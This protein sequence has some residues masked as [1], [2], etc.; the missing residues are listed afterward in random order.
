M[1]NHEFD[2][3]EIFKKYHEKINDAFGIDIEWDEN[4][5]TESC[6]AYNKICVVK[7]IEEVCR[8]TNSKDFMLDSRLREIGIKFLKVKYHFMKPEAYVIYDPNNI[9]TQ[10]SESASED[11]DYLMLLI[12]KKSILRAIAD[13]YTVPEYLINLQNMSDQN[14]IDSLAW[15]MANNASFELSEHAKIAKKEGIENDHCNYRTQTE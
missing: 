1:A 14:I 3:F 8:I 4:N 12:D 5:I 11:N 10:E 9:F 15:F 7:T 2:E 13:N 6:I